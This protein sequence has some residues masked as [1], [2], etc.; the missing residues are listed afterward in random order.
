MEMFQPNLTLS[1]EPDGEFTLSAVTV[2]PNS[3]YSAGRAQPGVP[4]DVRLTPEVFAVLLQ[5]RTRRGPCLQVLTPVRHQLRNLKLGPQHGMSSVL[6]FVMIDDRVAGSA[7]IPVQDASPSLPIKDRVTVDTSDWY[8]WMN[9][10]PPGPASFHITGVVHLP[11]PG[12]SASLEV[13]A[14]QGINPAAL[15]LDLRVKAL[16]GMWPQVVTPTMVRYDQSPCGV[17]YETV[18]VREPDGDAADVDVESVF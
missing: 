14:P 4:P 18:L 1:V 13:A 11:T 16:P 9:R 2:T 6:A 7:S 17:A 10:M 8:A 12:Y 5:L 3:C 15:I